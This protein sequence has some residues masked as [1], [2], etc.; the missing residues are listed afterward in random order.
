MQR[1]ALIDAAPRER[2]TKKHADRF[3]LTQGTHTACVCTLR[4]E[5]FRPCFSF[6]DCYWLLSSRGNCCS[7]VVQIAYIRWRLERSKHFKQ[8]S[9]C[10]SVHVE[11]LGNCLILN[12]YHG[13]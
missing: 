8:L 1:G 2:L 7:C 13:W 5:A 6:A 11:R 3:V 10:I 12:A 9:G 4:P